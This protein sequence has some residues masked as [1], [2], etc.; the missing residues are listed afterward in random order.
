ML[1]RTFECEKTYTSAKCVKAAQKRELTVAQKSKV[2]R[3]NESQSQLHFTSSGRSSANCVNMKGS[4]VHTKERNE[5]YFVIRRSETNAHIS[6]AGDNNLC[7]FNLVLEITLW[8]I[9]FKCAAKRMLTH[10]EI[11]QQVVYQTDWQFRNKCYA[12]KQ[13]YSIWIFGHRKRRE[14]TNRSRYSEQIKCFNKH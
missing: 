11:L 4:S 9:L 7:S 13:N 1:D 10:F 2:R 5:K 6:E 8:Q 14:P 12:Q 3:A